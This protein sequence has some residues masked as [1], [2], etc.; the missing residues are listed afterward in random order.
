MGDNDLAFFLD[1]GRSFQK[2]PVH[3]FAGERR[4]I[5]VHPVL[6]IQHAQPLMG[7]PSIIGGTG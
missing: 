6:R 1:A 5:R 7:I 3:L 2:A 4:N